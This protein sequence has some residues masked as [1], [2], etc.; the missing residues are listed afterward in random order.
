RIARTRPTVGP[1]IQ[2]ESFRRRR[3]HTAVLVAPAPPWGSF[4]LALRPCGYPSNGRNV[5]SGSRRS[6]VSRNDDCHEETGGVPPRR[7]QIRGAANNAESCPRALGDHFPRY[8]HRSFESKPAEG[9]YGHA[10]KSKSGTGWRRGSSC[11]A[12]G[13]GSIAS[14]A[15]RES[16]PAG[17]ESFVAIHGIGSSGCR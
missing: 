7:P 1:E 14:V 13:L 15:Q 3:F 8:R 17:R 4:R 12:C 2:G 11:Y 9:I 16:L 6:E 10:R 5:N